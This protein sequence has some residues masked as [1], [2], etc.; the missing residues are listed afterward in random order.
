MLRGRLLVVLSCWCAHDQSGWATTAEDAEACCRFRC[1]RCP[2][3]A[4]IL[5]PQLSGQRHTSCLLTTPQVPG[6]TTYMGCVGADHYAEELKKVASKDG[7]KASSLQLLQLCYCTFIVAACTL[8]CRAACEHVLKVSV[9]GSR[10]GMPGTGGADQLCALPKL[11]LPAHGSIGACGTG[12]A[13]T[14]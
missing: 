4:G 1:R 5:A 13:P 6:A 11:R 7:V 8:P 10:E 3:R 2:A 12:C 9:C 14:W